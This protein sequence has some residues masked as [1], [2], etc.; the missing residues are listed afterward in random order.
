MRH[1]EIIAVRQYPKSKMNNCY[2]FVKDE[3]RKTLAVRESLTEAIF[4][5]EQEGLILKPSL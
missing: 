2:W 3:K 1:V 5:V 4:Y